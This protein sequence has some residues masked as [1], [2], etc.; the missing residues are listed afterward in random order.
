M[1]ISIFTQC[2]D[3]WK[4]A[5]PFKVCLNSMRSFTFYFC[6]QVSKLMLKSRTAAPK[7]LPQSKSNRSF[8]LFYERSFM[9]PS[10][11]VKV[12][13]VQIAEKSMRV[14]GRASTLIRTWA[15]TSPLL[16]TENKLHGPCTGV[17]NINVSK[18]N[19]S[20]VIPYVIFDKT[21]NAELDFKHGTAVIS[22]N[23]TKNF[24]IK[25]FLTT[26]WE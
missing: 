5:S 16:L 8:D 3:S 22:W 13:W 19:R 21:G 14:A 1:N 15:P 10:S 26:I 11:L 18:L 7:F 23:I 17:N 4:K 2:F 12:I 24:F 20:K 6:N 25:G 9:A